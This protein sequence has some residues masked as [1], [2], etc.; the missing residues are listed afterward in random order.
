MQEAAASAAGPHYWETGSQGT[1][2]PRPSSQSHA[3]Q[4][5]LWASACERCVRGAR[6]ESQDLAI[7]VLTSGDSF[8][9]IDQC[10]S[11]PWSEK[12]LCP[13]GSRDV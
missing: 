7:I 9:P 3:C 6:G 2:V 11:Q 5:G 10:C 4:G 13:T 1:H 12:P 8:S